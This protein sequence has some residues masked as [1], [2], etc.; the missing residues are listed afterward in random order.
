MGGWV[1]GEWGCVVRG[2]WCVVRGA[3]RRA[4]EGG[5]AR[6]ERSPAGRPSCWIST[7]GGQCCGSQRSDVPPTLGLAEVFMKDFVD[8][9]LANIATDEYG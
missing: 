4:L 7:K 1:E 2:A 8:A 9:L 6:H 3:C 5:T